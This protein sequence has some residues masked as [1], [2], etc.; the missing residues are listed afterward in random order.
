LV[1][2][3]CHKVKPV[4][5]QNTLGFQQ[6][7]LLKQATGNPKSSTLTSTECAVALLG[8]PLAGLAMSAWPKPQKHKSLCDLRNMQ[9]YWNLGPADTE[10]FCDLLLTAMLFV[11]VNGS[12]IQTAVAAAPANSQLWR[13]VNGKAKTYADLR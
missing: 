12:P 2:S 5:S 9:T 11:L 4:F 8:F 6:V 1:L 3:V 10:F 7:A 13:L